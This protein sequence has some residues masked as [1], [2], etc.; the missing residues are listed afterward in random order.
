MESKTV[1]SQPDAHAKKRAGNFMAVLGVAADIA[2]IAAFVFNKDL[3]V[4]VQIAAIAGIAVGIF[5]L[6]RQ[7]GKPVGVRVLLAL[8]CITAGSVA[9][10]LSLQARGL[11]AST[12]GTSGTGATTVPPANSAA[13]STNITDSAFQFRLKPY[14]GI[15]L[16]AGQHTQSDVVD[17]DGPNGDIDIFMDEYGYLEINGGSFYLDTDGPDNEIHTRCS[18]ALTSQRDPHSKLLPSKGSRA[19][20]KTSGGKMGWFWSND[21]VL[22]GDLYVVLNVR[23]W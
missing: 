6:L 4:F 3:A 5:L 2:A 22:S 10:A 12:G 7:W 20:F 23:V 18:K 21:V 11:P 14:T 15:N 17:T 9:G 8:V 16:D 1:T 19:C 13:D